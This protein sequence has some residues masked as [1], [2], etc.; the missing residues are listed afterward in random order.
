VPSFHYGIRWASELKDLPSTKVRKIPSPIS[1]SYLL[2][3]ADC[4][5]QRD[6]AA[7]FRIL[8]RR[9]RAAMGGS[10]WAGGGRMIFVTDNPC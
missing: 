1:E 8:H 10:D 4:D 2:N 6:K 7:K 9:L 5:R 3:P